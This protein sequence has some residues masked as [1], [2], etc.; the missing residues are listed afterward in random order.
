MAGGVAIAAFGGYL[1]GNGYWTLAGAVVFTPVFMIIAAA[2][3]ERT[4]LG[5][6]VALPFMFYPATV[7]GFSL[8]L[9]I[10]TF[11]FTGLM[12]M[13]RQR[14]SLHGMRGV[15]PVATFAVVVAIGIYTSAASVDLATSFS[16]L[17]YLFLFGWFA[18]SLGTALFAGRLSR[19]QVARAVVWSGAIAAL[20]VLIQFLVQFGEGKESVIDWLR[21]VQATFAGERAANISTI[22]WVV[23]DFGLLRGI[24]PFMSPP[25]AGQYLMLCLVSAF[26]LRRERRDPTP[27]GSALQLALIVLITAALLVTFSRQAWIGALVGVI[28]LGIK[29]RPV[30]MFAVIAEMFLIF[31]VVPIPGGHGSFGDYLLTASDTSTTSSG[32]RVALWSQAIDLLPNHLLLGVGPGLYGTLNPDPANP[33]YYAH[34]VFLDELVEL[35]ALGGLAFIAVFALGLR[36]AFKRSATLAFAMLTA[37]VVAN[38]FD[39]VLFTPRNGLLLAVA[40]A[41]IV[42]G[43]EKRESDRQG[44]ASKDQL[45]QGHANK[46]HERTLASAQSA[47]AHR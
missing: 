26:W 37:Y 2:A 5:L 17:L 44:E 30:W 7:G 38:L 33:V 13:T 6:I 23:N 36:S 43:P 29:R 25:M 39:D 3:P 16:R 24:F 46:M 18:W 21:S 19:E 4:A 32:T 9:A 42:G 27:A 12:L 35:G 41:L 22:N 28:A 47:A 14:S 34:N 45:R 31:T 1:A 40:F 11:G 10:P 20:A 8:F 15:F